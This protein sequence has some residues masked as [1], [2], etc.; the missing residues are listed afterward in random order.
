MSPLD[1]FR[2]S[3]LFIAQESV[4]STTVRWVILAL[5]LVAALLSV[6]TVWYWKR[7]DPR[8]RVTNARH[9]SPERAEVPHGTPVPQAVPVQHV[10]SAQ[11]GSVAPTNG[12][13]TAGAW[14]QT[15]PS[16]TEAAADAR[17]RAQATG[18]AASPPDTTADDDIEA[19]DWLRLT[20]P[21]ALPRD[22][23]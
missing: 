6:L 15:P 5:L 18:M 3:G 16:A 2:V 11:R 20:G 13:T 14:G 17:R 9:V 22:N 12:E 23:T 4:T 7:T 10:A 19:D 1:S 21:Q 8:Q